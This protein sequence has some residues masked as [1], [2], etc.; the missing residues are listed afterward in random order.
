M[1]NPTCLYCDAVLQDK[2][3][4]VC[5]SHR[6]HHREVK[7][8]AKRIQYNKMRGVDYEGR[9]C[10][11]CGANI[12]HRTARAKRCEECVKAE[13]RREAR[14]SK[15]KKRG[16]K[17]E[18]KC[19]YCGETIGIEFRRDKKF[20]SRKCID[21][22]RSKFIDRTDYL[23]STQK[24]R[25]AYTRQWRKLNPAS[26]RNSKYKRRLREAS[27]VISERDWERTLNRFNRACAYCGCKGE[28][29]LDHV[30]PLS[31][32]GT[33]TVGNILPACRSCNSSKHA[34]FISEWKFIRRCR[35]V[36]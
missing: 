17:G 29:T 15:A 33:N 4:R 21:D 25:T 12:S 36:A 24:R 5:G 13:H 2:R 34:H 7:R 18:R 6:E 9:C 20:C 10:I 26:T 14:E 11:D 16:P 1:D 23:R 8:R 27:G 3:F 35:A 31:R 22:Y 32:G 19:L 28:I 30:V